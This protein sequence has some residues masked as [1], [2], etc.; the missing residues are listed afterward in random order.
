MLDLAENTD[1]VNRK[2]A[3]YSYNGDNIAQGRDNAVKYLEE[4]LE[5]A[6]TIEKQVREQLDMASITF[7]SSSKEEGEEEE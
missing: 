1:V 5:L 4:N 7:A 6:E 3:W 2:G